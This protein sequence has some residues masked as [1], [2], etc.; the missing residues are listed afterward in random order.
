MRRDHNSDDGYATLTAIVLC[1][2]A[3]MLCAG[4]LSVAAG[5]RRTETRRWARVLE[6]E[7][8]DTAVM[9]FAA[10][11]AG[12][13]EPYQVQ[14]SEMVALPS[15]QALS[16][17]LVAQSEAAKWPIAKVGDVPADVLARATGLTLARLETGAKGK[18]VYPPRDDCVRSLFSDLG[19]AD[20]ARDRP[21]IV[22]ALNASNA[23]DG[24]VWRIR[25]V[26]GNRVQE[27]RVRFLGDPR[28][29]FAT[30][31]VENLTLGEMPACTALTTRA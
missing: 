23:R 25:A 16:V 14:G 30:L 28:R 24:Q 31:S 9:R 26:T 29:P 2:A 6:D 21:T 3:A 20:P 22:S 4:V 17:T 13:R 18:G 8:L 10:R 5:E 1:G 19:Q 7:A 11:A 12:M 27:R 15:G